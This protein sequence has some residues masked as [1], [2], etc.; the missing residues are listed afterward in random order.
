M[1]DMEILEFINPATGEKFG[2]VK[3]HTPEQVQQAKCEMENA[4]AYWSQRPVHERIHVLRKFQSVMI[5]AADE[6]TATINRD[7]GKNRQEAMAEVFFSVDLLNRY[8]KKAPQW[9]RPERVSSGLYIF[10]RAYIEPKPFGVVGVISPWN[11]PFALSVPPVISALL[12]GNTVLLKPSEVTAA[13]GVLVE[14]LF[15]RVA[16]LAPFV[17]VLHGDGS[18]GAAMVQSAPDYIFLT[19]STATGRKVMQAAGEHLTPVACEL[20]GKDAMIVLEDADIEKAAR[21]GVWGAYFNAGQTCMSVERV[22]VVKEVYDDF[23]QH[24]VKYAR[25]YTVGYSS[26]RN[27]NLAMGAITDPRQVEII[28]RHMEDALA[29]GARIVLGGDRK[30]NFVGPTVLV[31]VD[32]SMLVM[33]EETFGPLLPIMQVEDEREAIRMANDNRYGLGA[34]IW[35]NDLERA[36]QVGEQVQAASVLIN[37]TVVQFVIPMLPFGGVKDSGF[38]RTHGKQGLLQFTQPYSYAIGKAPNDF[39]LATIGRE[40]GNYALLSAVMH[41]M[42]GTSLRQ[43]IKPVTNVLNEPQGRGVLATGLSLLAAIGLLIWSRNRK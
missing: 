33:Q 20:G 13:T 29:K 42:F 28:E 26:A 16:D 24:A 34:S 15:Q 19:G 43:R 8:L 6:I 37:D 35:S 21:W 3:M 36:R 30:E 11:Y 40:P 23:L 1:Q 27:S 25:R 41:L 39:D 14:R 5:D 9:L 7:C 22:Y 18:V 38:G 12:A 4:F 32:H 10:K 17:R 2:Q 31:D